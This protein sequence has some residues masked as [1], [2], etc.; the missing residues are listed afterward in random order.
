MKLLNMRKS[1][2]TIFLR[3]IVSDTNAAYA[4][5]LSQ[6]KNNMKSTENLTLIATFAIGLSPRHPTG[7]VTK[8]DM[9][10]ITKWTI[11][12]QYATTY[13]QLKRKWS[14]T[15]PPLTRRNMPQVIAIFVISLL[16]THSNLYLTNSCTST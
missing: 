15:K 6:E 12:A 10:G 5:S 8:K 4:A 11:P 2:T 9:Y 3:H 13:F 14:N 1:F 7:N 16:A